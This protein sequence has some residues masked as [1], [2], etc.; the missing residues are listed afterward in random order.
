MLS[1]GKYRQKVITLDRN[2]D[3]LKSYN[4]PLNHTGKLT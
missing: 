1:L 2:N 3:C 4:K